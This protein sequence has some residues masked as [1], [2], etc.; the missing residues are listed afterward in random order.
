[1]CIAAVT[2]QNFFRSDSG[3]APG[4][5]RTVTAGNHAARDLQMSNIPDDWAGVDPASNV[6]R[7]SAGTPRTPLGLPDPAGRGH[8]HPS[9]A[10]AIGLTIVTGRVLVLV[11]LLGLPLPRPAGDRPTAAAAVEV[12]P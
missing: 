3:L 5:R 8:S 1:L 9:T 2:V 12:V 6:F 7:T 10:L 11:L 4:A